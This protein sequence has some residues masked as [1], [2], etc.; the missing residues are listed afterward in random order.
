MTG[1]YTKRSGEFRLTKPFNSTKEMSDSD[2]N[3]ISMI[4]L[5]ASKYR[6]IYYDSLSIYEKAHLESLKD[7]KFVHV[8]YADDI[9]SKIKCKALSHTNFFTDKGT[10]VSK[11]LFYKCYRESFRKGA[12]SKINADIIYDGPLLCAIIISN[13]T[14]QE[15]PCNE[16]YIPDKVEEH[17]HTDKCEHMVED[18]VEDKVE[19]HVHTDK[20]EHT[21]EDTVEDMV[22]KKPIFNEIINESEDSDYVTIDMKKVIGEIEI[23]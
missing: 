22:E 11:E 1:T 2:K 12:V 19:E 16:H 23:D 5:R 21:V 7:L 6:R 3:F 17:V 14:T 15:N 20:C 4:A 10:I 13:V 8:M 18:K 9:I